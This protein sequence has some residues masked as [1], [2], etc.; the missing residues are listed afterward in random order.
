MLLVAQPAHCSALLDEAIPAHVRLGFSRLLQAY[1]DGLHVLV[2]PPQLCSAIESSALFSE[3]E[4]AAARKV[5]SRFAEYGALADELDIYGVLADGTATSP[6][7]VGRVWEVP[8]S[9]IAQR[10][11]HELQLLAEDLRDIGVLVGAAEDYLHHERFHAFRVRVAGVPGGGGNTHRVLVHLAIDA[12]RIC[13][14]V[15]DSDR[16]CP[17]SPLGPSAAACVQIAGDGLF[18]VRCTQGRSME[19]AVPARLLDLIRPHNVPL[20]S[21]LLAEVNAAKSGA[22]KFVNLKRGLFGHDLARLG[23]SACGNYWHEVCAVVG[24]KPACCSG[25]CAAGKVG[26][27]NYQILPGLGNAT[28]ADVS[29]RLIG[30]AT[31]PMRRSAYLPSPESAEWTDLGRLVFEFGLGLPPRRI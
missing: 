21:A 4:R 27:C 6:A 16:E 10:P 15:A 5:R 29:T 13:L 14:C 31:D 28:L 9:W 22:G 20:P 12:Q 17:I 1:L 2:M 30:T 24:S 18:E 3:D 25:G 8:L 26:D 23:G 19:N 7:R 11:L